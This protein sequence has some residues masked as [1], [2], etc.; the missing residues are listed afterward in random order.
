MDIKIDE[1]LYNRAKLDLNKYLQV[2]ITEVLFKLQQDIGRDYMSYLPT[3]L[4][5][6]D[7]NF[8]AS[9]LPYVPVP[10]KL[11]DTQ[12]TTLATEYKKQQQEVVAGVSVFSHKE[13]YGSWVCMWELE[14]LNRLDSVSYTKFMQEL[15]K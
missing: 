3:I 15:F 10:I 14:I 12:I 2:V 1:E 7:T 4:I 9:I 6:S 5:N 11:F 13:T 8:T